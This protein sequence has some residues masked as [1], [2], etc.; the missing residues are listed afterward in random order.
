MMKDLPNCFEFPN[1][2]IEYIPSKSGLF[3]CADGPCQWLFYK[4]DFLGKQIQD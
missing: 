2:T 4:L 1:V 3:E